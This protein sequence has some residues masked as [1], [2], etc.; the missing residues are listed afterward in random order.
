LSR[1][2]QAGCGKYIA[3]QLGEVDPGALHSISTKMSYYRSAASLLHRQA[4]E[5]QKE[6]GREGTERQ[7][8]AKSNLLQK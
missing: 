8:Y 2:S 1:E 4:A 5:A 6:R 7:M 3:T